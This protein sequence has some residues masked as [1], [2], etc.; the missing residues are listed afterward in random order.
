[1][2]HPRSPRLGIELEV[3]IR[4]AAER[5]RNSKRTVALTGAG[6]SVESGIPPFR[7]ET[8]AAGLWDRFDPM[9][10]GSIEAF[11]RDPARVW[12]MLR[13]L[14]STLGRARPN[15]GHL[16]L[17]R[18]EQ[19]GLLSSIITQN[20]DG[21]HQVAGCRR[22]VEF[23]GNWATMTCLGCRRTVDSRAVSLATLPPRCTCGAPLKPDVTLFGEIIPAERIDAAYEAVRSCDCL[24]IVGT[25]AEV[26]PASA[27]PEAAR[28]SGAFVIE[29]NPSETRLDPLVHVALRG[30]AAVILPCLADEICT[31]SVN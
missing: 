19:E 18:M 25:S 9:Q 2:P 29:V 12:L 11:V 10:Y 4:T 8:G 28:D 5:L 13:E 16:A 6:L 21:L 1:M 30:P 3:L 22:V 15:S 27:L 24:L 23:H 17:A 31:G 7:T 26:A 14:A 20:I